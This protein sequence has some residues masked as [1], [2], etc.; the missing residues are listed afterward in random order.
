MFFETFTLTS[1]RPTSRTLSCIH[2]IARQSIWCFIV[3]KDSEPRRLPAGG[4]VVGVVGGGGGGMAHALPPAPRRRA[5]P[6]SPAARHAAA[7]AAANRGAPAAPPGTALIRAGRPRSE[8]R[9]A[10]HEPGPAR[11][12]PGMRRRGFSVSETGIENATGRRPP[13]LRSISRKM[14]QNRRSWVAD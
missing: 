11:H 5:A 13:Y 8:P 1:D 9:G 12:V 4:G 14:P 6:S 7:A 2:L 3:Q 10:S